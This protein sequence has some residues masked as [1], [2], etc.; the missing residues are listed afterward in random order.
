MKGEDAKT[1]IRRLAFPGNVAIAG[2]GG[3]ILIK[4]TRAGIA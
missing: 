2:R 1:P 3:S 4:D